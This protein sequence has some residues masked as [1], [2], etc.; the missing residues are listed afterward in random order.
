MT[1]AMPSRFNRWRRSSGAD[2]LMRK[3]FLSL[4]YY[5]PFLG[6]GKRSCFLHLMVVFRCDFLQLLLFIADL[7]RISSYIYADDITRQQM[8]R[9]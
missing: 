6:R 7:A 9:A 2:S 1:C 8:F 4:H 5:V 3:Q